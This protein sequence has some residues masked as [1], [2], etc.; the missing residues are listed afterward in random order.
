MTDST[1]CGFIESTHDA[2]TGSMCGSHLVQKYLF[3]P[4][5]SMIETGHIGH[6]GSLVRLRGVNDVWSTE[7]QQM[8]SEEL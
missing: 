3:C 7:T 2:S 4:S 5:E 6:D 1:F 8:T